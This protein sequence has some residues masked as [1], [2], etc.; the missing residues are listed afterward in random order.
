METVIG[1]EEL[2]SQV[3]EAGY[4]KS[5]EYSPE[6]VADLFLSDFKT[7][8]NSPGLTMILPIRNASPSSPAT[9]CSIQA[10][11]RATSRTISLPG[12]SPSNSSCHGFR[13]RQS[14]P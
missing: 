12:G 5:I 6:R 13:T 3:A 8:A 14:I 11:F 9:Y 10:T 4:R 2:L 7:S 1:D